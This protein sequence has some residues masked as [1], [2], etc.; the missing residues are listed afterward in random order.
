MISDSIVLSLYDTNLAHTSS[1]LMSSTIRG[2]KA[3]PWTPIPSFGWKVLTRPF[4]GH[5]IGPCCGRFGI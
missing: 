3:L 2:W 4:G 5:I 1:K